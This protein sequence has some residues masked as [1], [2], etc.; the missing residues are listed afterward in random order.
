MAALFYQHQRLKK[1]RPV[2]QM[3][4]DCVTSG[5]LVRLPGLI[6]THV[7]LR[8]PGQTHKEDF[9]SGTKAALAG[10][11]TLI[12]AMPNTNPP[13]VD[14]NTFDL[15]QGIAQEKAHCDYAIYLG[16]T[17]F[18]AASVSKLASKAAALKMYCNETFTTLTM[19]VRSGS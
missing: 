3:H 1:A 15:V 11:V 16:A 6:D 13:I 8:D 2:T 12:A 10:G 17:P 19:K 4:I 18:N 9:E 5:R 14:E 7:H